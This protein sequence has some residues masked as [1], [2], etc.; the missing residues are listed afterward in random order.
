MS[1]WE[2]P[3]VHLLSKQ[4]T[5]PSDRMDYVQS[6]KYWKQHSYLKIEDLPGVRLHNG[7]RKLLDNEV[8]F[9][10]ICVEDLPKDSKIVVIYAG[11]APGF[12]LKFNFRLFPMVS[13]W[14]LVDPAR[15]GVKESEKVKIINGLFT[16]ELALKLNQEYS[17]YEICFISDIRANDSALDTKAIE[18]EMRMQERW[19]LIL[20]PYRSMF[21]TRFPYVAEGENTTFNYKPED[22]KKYTYLDGEIYTQ[23]WARNKSAETRLITVPFKTRRWKNMPP[24]KTKTYNPTFY[25]SRVAM[26]IVKVRSSYFIHPLRAYKD[27][28][29][30]SYDGCR[31]FVIAMEYYRKIGRHIPYISSRVK[32]T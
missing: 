26:M 24:P 4:H 14:I 11:S 21:K 29:S 7:Q 19:H 28:I 17:D 1:F 6:S 8:E 5:Y 16:D 15:F 20:R 23:P 27:Y 2:L 10:T 30:N 12:H 18:L 25:E 3:S 9:L 22:E 13:K 32:K 31:E